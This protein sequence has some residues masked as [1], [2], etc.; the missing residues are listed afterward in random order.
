[1]KE[2]EMTHANHTALAPILVAVD[3]SAE[4]AEALR[5]A[6]SQA[7]TTGSDL[8]VIT[9][10]RHHY[11]QGEAP[12]VSWDQFESTKRSAQTRALDVIESVLGTDDVDHTLTLGPVDAALIDH[13]R[14]ASMI[15][16]GTRSSFGLPDTSRPSTTDRVTGKVRCPV[17]SIPL[18][19]AVL[20]GAS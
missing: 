2:I 17:V 10:Y 9:C 19:T 3:G 14:D 4:S 1:M 20:E 11:V 5:W 12:F 16:I 13:G 6:A 7:Q 15:V 18:D 8:K